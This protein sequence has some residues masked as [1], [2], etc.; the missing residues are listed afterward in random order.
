MHLY[1]F[2]WTQMRY[3]GQILYCIHYII[4]TI[5]YTMEG[6]WRSL[7]MDGHLKTCD[8]QRQSRDVIISLREKPYTSDRHGIHVGGPDCGGNVVH[9]NNIVLTIW[10]CHH[11]TS[12]H[13]KYKSVTWHLTACL[14]KISAQWYKFVR[15]HLICRLRE[16][17]HWKFGD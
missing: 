6:C 1:V 16:G 9:L 3:A 11:F 8:Q 2:S 10:I 17:V 14:N 5:L 12:T 15:W 4:Y 13:N 7:I